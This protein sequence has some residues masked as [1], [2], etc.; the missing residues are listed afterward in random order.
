M[1]SQP[2]HTIHLHGSL[3]EFGAAYQLAVS[4]PLEAVRALSFQIKGFAEA[5]QTGMFRIVRGKD[6]DFGMHY[7]VPYDEEQ[8]KYD[9]SMLHF[10]LGASGNDLHIVPVIAGAGG[11]GGKAIL[12]AIIMVAAVAA[13]PFTLGTSLAGGL[14]A[15]SFGVGG[16]TAFTFGAALVL[17]GVGAML[18]PSVKSSYSNNEN[19]D[20]RASF[21]LGGQT[22]QNSQGGP[23][24]LAY[25]RCRVGSTVISAGLSAERI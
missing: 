17:G 24:V 19:P 3:A 11:G 10:S 23:V 21:F 8:N 13:A 7:E 15:F 12:G 16:A 9:I 4:T 6:P 25:G 20:Q 2:M 22:N 18:Q 5:M 1:I 14:S